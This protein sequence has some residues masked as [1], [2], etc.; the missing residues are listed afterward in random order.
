MLRDAT[1]FEW[2]GRRTDS[3]TAIF[4]GIPTG[5]Y[6][7]RLD[8][9]SLNEPVRVEQDLTVEVAPH[10]RTTLAV[11]VRGRVIRIISPPGRSGR[12]SR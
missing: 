8:L 12:V 6:T 2:V 4:E 7:L 9:S 1:G 10:V 3:T 5:Q 11:P